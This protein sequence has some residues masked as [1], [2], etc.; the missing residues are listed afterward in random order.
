VEFPSVPISNNEG[1][2]WKPFGESFLFGDDAV[3][4]VISGLFGSAYVVFFSN[5][6]MLRASTELWKY[7]QKSYLQFGYESHLMVR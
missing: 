3:T 5:G 1:F 6:D 7:G 4:A 2:C